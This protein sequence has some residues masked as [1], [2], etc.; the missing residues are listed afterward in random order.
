MRTRRV[1]YRHVWNNSLKKAQA[2]YKGCLQTKFWLDYPTTPWGPIS[3]FSLCTSLLK[4]MKCERSYIIQTEDP[5]V[6]NLG[7]CSLDPFSLCLFVTWELCHLQSLTP[8]NRVTC[9]GLGS[10][11]TAFIFKIAFRFS[12]L[13]LRNLTTIPF[14]TTRDLGLMKRNPTGE[15]EC[16]A[17]AKRWRARC[18]SISYRSCHQTGS[19]AF[20][21]CGI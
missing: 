17:V 16:V 4:L 19:A 12:G 8:S 6:S 5:V 21:R 3:L 2:G 10:C 20:H 18:G 7:R 14:D 13:D 9:P 1:F 11:L 15:Q